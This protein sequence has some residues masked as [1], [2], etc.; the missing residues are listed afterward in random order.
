MS[1]RKQWKR[2]ARSTA[3]FA[4]SVVHADHAQSGLHRQLGDGDTGYLIERALDEA[5]LA[6]V[7]TY[8]R[9]D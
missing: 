5:R 1:R 7:Q 8:C 2:T 9:L 6:A 3:R 4:A